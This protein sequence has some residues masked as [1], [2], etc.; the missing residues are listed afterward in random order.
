[1]TSNQ[2]LNKNTKEKKNYYRGKN[3]LTDILLIDN[4]VE[5]LIG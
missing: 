2:L 5:L 1:M 3:S 4:G